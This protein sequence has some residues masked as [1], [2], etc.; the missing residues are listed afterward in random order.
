MTNREAESL[1]RYVSNIRLDEERRML[2]ETAKRILAISPHPD[3]S[4]LIAGGYLADAVAGGA[5]VKIV[6]VT[7]GRMGLLQKDKELSED[8]VAALR[9]SEQLE[10]ASVLGVKDI[11][12]L[13]YKD[14]EA[15]SPAVLTKDMIRIIRTY[16][17]DLVVTVDP[18]LPYESHP[19]HV[20][21]GLAVM[22]AVMFHPLPYIQGSVKINSESPTV[23][24]GDSSSPN[25][26]VPI[27]ETFDKK[28]HSIFCHKSQFPDTRSVRE[29]MTEISSALGR[30]IGATHGEAFKVLHPYETHMDVLASY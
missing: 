6:I 8:G 1:R 3:D 16:R 18:F 12:F 25:V 28:L 4:E 24:L 13:E 22:R 21:T 30:A 23:S 17:P 9:K 26:I 10:A 15:P 20:N 27:D 5:G 2:L 29:K 19:D 7:D 14:T 11:Q